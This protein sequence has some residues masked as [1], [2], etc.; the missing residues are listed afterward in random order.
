[1]D[2]T[3]GA[4]LRAQRE[5]QAVALSAISEQ[6]KIRLSLLEELE[7]DNVSHW[8]SGIFRRS[9]LRTYAQ[10]IGLD[11][12]PT[13]RE[14]LDLYPDPLEEPTTAALLAAQNGSPRE[15][16]GQRPNSRLHYMIGSAM[17][18]LPQL[19]RSGPREASSGF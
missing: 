11:P 13:V 10:A 16:I 5:R 9:Y 15:T 2:L 17:S 4:R 18:A 1:M 8:P 14:F 7:Q 3:F 6:T 19:L 12:E